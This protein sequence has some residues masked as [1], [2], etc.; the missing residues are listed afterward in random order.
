M[1]RKREALG[2][3]D[4]IPYLECAVPGG[5]DDET[6]IRTHR[7]VGDRG[8]M[9]VQRSEQCRRR[10]RRQRMPGGEQWSRKL[11]LQARSLSGKSGFP[12]QMTEQESTHLPFGL[13]LPQQVADASDAPVKRCEEGWN[14]SRL[15]SGKGCAGE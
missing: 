2:S 6:A 7:T 10:S 1:A 15:L 9:A 5:R 11:L 12:A 3:R 13:R 14:R 4:R 8:S